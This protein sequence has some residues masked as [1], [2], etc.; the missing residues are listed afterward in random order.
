[1]AEDFSF[2]RLCGVQSIQSSF[3]GI[4]AILQL[5]SN[6]ALGPKPSITN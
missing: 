1:M 2:D 4:K 6:L 5:P 3:G